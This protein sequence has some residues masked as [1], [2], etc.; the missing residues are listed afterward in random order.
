MG[1]RLTDDALDAWFQAMPVHVL[2][3]DTS[4]VIGLL[5]AEIRERRA[6]D[7]SG[8]EVEALRY[9]RRV[10]GHSAAREDRMCADA[11]T[12]IDKIVAAHGTKP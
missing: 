10:V 6:A 11:V 8:A 3:P 2:G 5:V 7:L 1:E 4:K 9:L 12:A